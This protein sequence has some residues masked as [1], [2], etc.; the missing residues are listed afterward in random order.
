MLAPLRLWSH[1]TVCMIQTLSGSLPGS[2]RWPVLWSIHLFL[3]PKSSDT[4]IR[5]G[6]ADSIRERA[7]GSLP[8]CCHKG[9]RLGFQLAP[10]NEESSTNRSLSWSVL[11]NRSVSSKDLVFFFWFVGISF[12]AKLVAMINGRKTERR[13]RLHIQWHGSPGIWY[14][15]ET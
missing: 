8:R 13:F 6:S 10:L 1:C 3:L 9:I 12:S 7:Y 4:C 14:S 11:A 2:T 15:A 5:T